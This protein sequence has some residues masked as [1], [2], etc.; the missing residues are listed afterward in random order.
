MIY[1]IFRLIV[2]LVSE[3]I[4]I[5]IIGRYLQMFCNDPS[6]QVIIHFKQRFAAEAEDFTD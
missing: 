5:L 1:E 6:N 2:I 3:N 4:P